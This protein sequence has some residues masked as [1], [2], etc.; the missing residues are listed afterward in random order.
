MTFH[1]ER[2]P[3]E[4]RHRSQGRHS[5]LNKKL[6]LLRRNQGANPVVAAFERAD[7]DALIAKRKKWEEA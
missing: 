4:P 1:P 2:T 5:Q 7:Y 3:R 6:R